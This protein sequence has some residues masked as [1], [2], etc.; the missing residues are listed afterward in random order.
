MFKSV[1]E[2]RR[3]WCQGTTPKQIIGDGD[4]EI[5]EAWGLPEFTLHY[6]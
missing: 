6:L 1:T 3:S 2:I 4:I 5:V